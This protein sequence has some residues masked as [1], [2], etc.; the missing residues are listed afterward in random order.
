QLGTLFQAAKRR[1]VL[2]P[3]RSERSGRRAAVRS[4]WADPSGLAGSWIHWT[5]APPVMLER[6]SSPGLESCL[7]ERPRH[8]V[9]AAALHWARPPA[10]RR[11]VQLVPPVQLQPVA[12]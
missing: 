9:A 1:P 3:G 6:L 5:P 7:A 4:A 11:R 2:P 10:D 8:P 12:R